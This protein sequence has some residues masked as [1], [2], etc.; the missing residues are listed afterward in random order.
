MTLAVVMVASHSNINSKR[1]EGTSSYDITL[2]D[3][4]IFLFGEIGTFLLCVRKIVEYFKC[5]K[6]RHTSRRLE[7]FNSG[8]CFKKF[9]W[10]E[11]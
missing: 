11:F 2:V 9:Q 4:N 5:C 6:I 8:S 7:D 1:E 3:I 10:K